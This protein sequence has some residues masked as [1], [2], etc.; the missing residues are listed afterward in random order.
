ENMA[1]EVWNC[2]EMYD[3]EEKVHTFVMDNTSNNDTLMENITIKC[4]MADIPFDATDTRIRC[5]PHTA[6]LAAIKV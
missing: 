2:I 4:A 1:K 5:M 3:L 6:H